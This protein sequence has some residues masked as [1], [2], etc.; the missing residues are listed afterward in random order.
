MLNSFQ[1]YLS[2]LKIPTST[3]TNLTIT[4]WTL[5][6]GSLLAIGLG[7]YYYPTICAWYSAYYNSSSSSSNKTPYDWS[8][9]QITNHNL[10]LSL[11]NLDKIE[12][13]LERVTTVADKLDATLK[14]LNVTL[15]KTDSLF[16]SSTD[17]V[18]NLIIATDQ[19]NTN[20]G[21]INKAAKFT[22]GA[23]VRI[24]RLCDRLFSINKATQTDI[25]TVPSPEDFDIPCSLEL[26]EL[27]PKYPILPS[28][29]IIIATAIL[30][31][32]LLYKMYHDRGTRKIDA[33]HKGGG[34][35][36][37]QR[38]FLS[39]RVR[40]ERFITSFRSTLNHIHKLKW[41]IVGYLTSCY[42]GLILD[43]LSPII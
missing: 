35:S 20:I 7:I 32:H 43:L 18:A 1:N 15:D 42:I 19:V 13:Q 37:L 12:A 28:S 3:I 2:L 16:K 31:I 14:N 24:G 11:E 33:S 27:F 36:I 9:T 5:I 21:V 41:F 10:G 29:F 17:A 6:G 34:G 22:N 23:V 8:D 4:D 25:N 39:V 40:R 26:S 38:L 30:T